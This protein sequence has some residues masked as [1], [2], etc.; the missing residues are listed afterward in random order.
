MALS[1]INQPFRYIVGSASAAATLTGAY[2]GN[3]KIFKVEGFVEL[4]LYLE[5]TPAE[6]DRTMSIQV[7]GSPDGVTFFPLASL[8][9][10][11]PFDGSAKG[12]DYVKTMVSLGASVQRMRFT[13]PLADI[14][15]RVSVKEDGSNFGTIKV[16]NLISGQ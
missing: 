14:S 7:E 8:Q 6:A 15:C 4:T 11:N 2:T 13:Y 1:Y 5:Y 10:T 12:L 3:T 9:D 16:I